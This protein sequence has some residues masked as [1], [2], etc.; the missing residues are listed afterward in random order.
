MVLDSSL[1]YFY[2]F[3]IFYNGEELVKFEVLRVVGGGRFG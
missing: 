1:D 2:F 3:R